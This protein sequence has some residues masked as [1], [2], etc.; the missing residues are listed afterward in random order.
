MSSP[1]KSEWS[2]S[3]STPFWIVQVGQ[4]IESGVGLTRSST[5]STASAAQLAV[6]QVATWISSGVPQ[7]SEQEPSMWGKDAMVETLGSTSDRSLDRS[8]SGGATLPMHESGIERQVPS[9]S[10]H[11]SWSAMQASTRWGTAGVVPVIAKCVVMLGSGS[12]P[13]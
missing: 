1:L 5:G 2:E 4:P 11:A 6:V 10:L 3:D 13:S 9:R 8:V 12:P 7:L